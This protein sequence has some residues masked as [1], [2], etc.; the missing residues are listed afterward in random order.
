MRPYTDGRLDRY[1][2]S[3]PWELS[4]FRTQPLLSEGSLTCD[5]CHHRGPMESASRL[6]C[7]QSVSNQ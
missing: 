1:R 2:I 5:P 6:Q 4:E 7:S 3:I